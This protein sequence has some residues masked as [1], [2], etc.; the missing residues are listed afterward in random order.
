MTCNTYYETIAFFL[1]R[2]SNEEDLFG[3]TVF[4]MNEQEPNDFC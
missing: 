2:Y 3:L 4:Y 1:R